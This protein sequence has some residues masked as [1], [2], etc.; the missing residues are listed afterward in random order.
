VKCHGL[1]FNPELIGRASNWDLMFKTTS[2]VQID[3]FVYTIEV[4]R[5]SA[6]PAL[7]TDYF[8]PRN[9]VYHAGFS[10]PVSF[11]GPRHAYS[12]QYNLFQFACI[13]SSVNAISDY[14]FDFCR[15]VA[16][17]TFEK[18]SSLTVLAGGTFKSCSS[19]RSIC[20]PSSVELLCSH[21][22]DNCDLLSYIG[23]AHG[24]RLSALK[25]GAFRSCR[26]LLWLFLPAGL[27]NATGSSFVG[28]TTPI[29]DIDPDNSVLW[30]CGNFV[31][32]L[33]AR[34]A[35]RYFGKD[36]EVL[37]DKRF[38]GIAS[39][40]FRNLHHVLAIQFE[41]GSRVSSIGTGAFC[42]CSRLES[43]SIP[44]T[45]ECI[46][47]QCFTNCISLRTVTFESVSRVSVLGNYAFALCETL[48]SIRIPSSVTQIGSECFR[49]CSSLATVTV[50]D[51]I[52]LSVIAKSAFLDC[53][54]LLRLPSPLI[55]Q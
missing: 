46:P 23:F 18:E 5:A 49:G 50:E 33:E 42:V 28:L 34:S 10:I 36:K 22:F 47:S 37:I 19:L 51:R 15:T 20:I 30:V 26:S 53:P 16:I 13:S 12:G 2:S 38:S 3:N 24:S 48:S 9:V 45:I 4:L 32:N 11:L 1:K 40:C 55:E 17:V 14:Y 8:L 52:R 41:V 44:S 54:S 27:E 39:D 35:L 6:R 29:I 25:Y 7:R 43:F 31:V 21:C